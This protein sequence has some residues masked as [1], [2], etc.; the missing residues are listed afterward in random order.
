MVSD[1]FKRLMTGSALLCAFVAVSAVHADDR[2][3]EMALDAYV[4][5]YPMVLMETTRQVSTNV[6]APAGMFAPMNRW[7]HMRSF[8]DATFKDVVRPNAD[9]LYSI[10]WYDL[11]K[12]PLVIS[13]A[14]SQGR[15]YMLP[16]L[17]MWSDVV[18]VPGSR[19]SGDGAQ[20][21]ALLGPGWKGSVP[22]GVEPIRCTTNVGWIIGRT[23][24]KGKAD[25]GNVHAFQDTMKAVP[26]SHWGNPKY[27][28]PA[29]VKVMAGVDRKTPPPAQVAKMDAK[30]YFTLFAELMKKNPPH[31]MDWNI[32]EYLK[33]FNI[34]PGRSFDYKSLDAAHKAA[35]TKA[36]AQA[37]P[38]I[39][40]HSIGEAVNGWKIAREFMGNYGNSYMQR[41]FI[42]LIGLG[43]NPVE[44]AVYPMSVVDANGEP[45]SGRYKYVLHF[46]KDDLPPV[47]G[48]WSLTMYNEDMYFA[49]NPINRYAIGDRNP[50]KYNKDGSLDLLISYES[51]GKE[52]ESNWLPAPDGKFDLVLRLYWPKMEVLDGAWNPPAVHR[53]R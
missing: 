13:V 31:E 1:W 33:A 4:Y 37:Q 6:E 20:T 21:F 23:N 46:D 24:T 22:K 11:S 52:K 51:P 38:M 43:A 8:P 44:D 34:V 19:T 26:L 9:T 49:A 16:I 45:Y 14:A 2:L 50:L 30:S 18:A 28:P 41:A 42:A 47:R 40:H 48:F 10:L 53:V 5:A 17:D 3:D 25:F 35:L 12:E 32:L 39:L 27:T 15:Y 29:K 36:V 7:A